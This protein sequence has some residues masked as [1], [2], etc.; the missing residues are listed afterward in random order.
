MLAR[1][2][3]TLD[4]LLGRLQQLPEAV[5]EDVQAMLER[6][7]AIRARYRFLRDQRL[8]AMRIR[9]HGDLHLAQALYTGKD[10]VLIDFEGDPA[11][12][13]SERR[14]KRSPLEDL[15][16]M[17][18]SFYAAAQHVHYGEAREGPA[19]GA[20][21]RAGWARYW[22]RTVGLAFLDAYLQTPGVAPL[23]PRNPEHLRV[24]TRLYIMD[25]AMRR[26]QFEL[27]HA[28]E[29]VR[30][31]CRLVVDLLEAA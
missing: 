15:A 9:I 11:R 28:P 2:R 17:F 27:A 29:L 26:L 24:L 20:Q 1:M 16:S 10:F 30:M 6:H 18:A 7:D 12:P 25:L 3:R 22:A 4:Q 14:I 5:R 8:D 13:L 23:L 19:P 31:P 21:A